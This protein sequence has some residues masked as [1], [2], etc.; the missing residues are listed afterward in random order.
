MN[1]CSCFT[2]E[3]SRGRV[4]KFGGEDKVVIIFT[5]A[6]IQ[7]ADWCSIFEIDHSIIEGQLQ[8]KVS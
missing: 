7:L 6:D 4:F 8:L 5:S 1:G 3:G 2:V